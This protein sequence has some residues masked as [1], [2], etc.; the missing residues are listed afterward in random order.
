M[1]KEEVPQF[2][3]TGVPN[4]KKDLD[5]DPLDEGLILR[6][7]IQVSG[8][9]TRETQH[10]TSVA[11]K[12]SDR[13]AYEFSDFVLIAFKLLPGTL[14]LLQDN[15]KEIIKPN[16]KQKLQRHMKSTVEGLLKWQDN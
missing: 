7:Q 6:W 8:H 16:H 11:A 14:T 3:D 9:L 15:N 13:L 5:D 1:E 10:M 12:G 4:K 2:D